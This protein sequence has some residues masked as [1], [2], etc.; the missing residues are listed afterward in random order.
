MLLKHPGMFGHADAT[1]NQ[2]FAF[3]AA[4]GKVKEKLKAF[5]CQW[6]VLEPLGKG[7]FGTVIS[8]GFRHLALASLLLINFI[9]I[10]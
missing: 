3:K 7:G 5:D 10:Y 8:L 1:F 4:K 6:E 9:I 2:P